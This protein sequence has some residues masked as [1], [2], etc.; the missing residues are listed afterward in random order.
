M[1][2]SPLSD[3]GAIHLRSLF[4]VGYQTTQRVPGE[5]V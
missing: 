2:F 5:I 3:G 4:R 1:P